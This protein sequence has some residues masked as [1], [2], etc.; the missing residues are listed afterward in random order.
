MIRAIAFDWGGV[1]T[2]A[3]FDSSAIAALAEAYELPSAQVET[4]YLPL[5]VPFEE[6]ALD[7]PGFQRRLEADLTRAGGG[8]KVLDEATFRS[9]FLGAVAWREPMVPLLASIPARFTVGMLSNNVPELCDVVR[10]DPRMARVERFVF[11]N[12]IASRKPASAAFEALTEA[13]GVPPADTLFVDDNEANVK[14]CEAL[15]FR[16]LRIGERAAFA[17]DWQAVLPEVPLPPS[18]LAPAD[19]EHW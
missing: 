12:E 10:N 16:G 14:A 19:G 11:S 9:T 8:A 15:G 6:G 13:L 2:R 4:V 5:M 7:L 3:T 18:L 17:S 1:F